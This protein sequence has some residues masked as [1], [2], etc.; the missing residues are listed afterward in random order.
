M[1]MM[2]GHHWPRVMHVAWV[3]VALGGLMWV[4][5]YVVVGSCGGDDVVMVME[6]GQNVLCRVGPVRPFWLLGLLPTLLS[7]S[8]TCAAFA[9]VQ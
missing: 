9:D 5:M 4:C 2:M 3:M 8:P 6:C 1:M 7:V